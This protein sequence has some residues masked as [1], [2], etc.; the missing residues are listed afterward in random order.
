MKRQFTN[1]SFALWAACSS[2][3]WGM[4]AG[5]ELWDGFDF[6]PEGLFVGDVPGFL[7][8]TPVI[9]SESVADIQPVS[10]VAS[11]S[12]SAPKF[13]RA[14][15]TG[16]FEPEVT[17]Q[18]P[19]AYIHTH[20]TSYIPLDAY[21]STLKPHAPWAVHYVRDVLCGAEFPALHLER[22]IPLLEA[23][24]TPENVEALIN[25]YST[26][27]MTKYQKKAVVNGLSGGFKYMGRDAFLGQLSRS[28]KE[29][30]SDEQRKETVRMLFVLSQRE[31]QPG[32]ILEN[33]ARLLKIESADRR[34][35]LENMVEG[36][37]KDNDFMTVLLEGLDD[38][39]IFATLKG[40][41]ERVIGFGT[42]IP[43]VPGITPPVGPFKKA[44]G[45]IGVDDL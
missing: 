36:F 6:K 39:S 3:V 15:P 11:D 34:K 21:T 45:E 23:Q 8:H 1:L 26:A 16:D 35:A 41:C 43:R 24:K 33:S 13:K 31:F 38:L 28:W 20:K 17:P 12:V 29:S 44:W 42:T 40:I 19:M 27:T 32:F 18:D 22:L 37:F 5:D 25:T 7:A 2:T 14:R 30:L 4:D 10:S 9:G